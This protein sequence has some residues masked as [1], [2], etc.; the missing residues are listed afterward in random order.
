ME[1]KSRYSGVIGTT[2]LYDNL[3][4]IEQMWAWVHVKNG[5]LEFWNPVWIIKLY[6]VGTAITFGFGFW[7]TE[8]KN[9]DSIAV[10]TAE[11]STV[12][13][14]S[15]AQRSRLTVNL[16]DAGCMDP[17]VEGMLLF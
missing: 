2:K 12:D 13:V 15:A 7:P 17:R 3:N 8:L 16:A 11:T 4:P 6:R 5:C 1:P 10:A 14:T 9:K